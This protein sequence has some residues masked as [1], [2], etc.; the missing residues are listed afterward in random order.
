[1]DAKFQFRQSTHFLT[2]YGAGSCPQIGVT[3][4]NGKSLRQFVPFNRFQGCFC[5]HSRFSMSMLICKFNQYC[6]QSSH[7]QIHM[8]IFWY[9]PKGRLSMFF[10]SLEIWF[11]LKFHFHHFLF[12]DRPHV[13]SIRKAKMMIQFGNLV[14][15]VIFGKDPPSK[16]CALILKGII[17]Q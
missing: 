1:M 6:Q 3:F 4:H 9:S 8:E 11:I 17:S 12:L 10:C 16:C 13:V 2:S 14:C 7:K 5:H 15:G